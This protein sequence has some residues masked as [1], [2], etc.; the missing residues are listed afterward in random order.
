M[1]VSVQTP[2]WKGQ[3]PGLALPLAA[4]AALPAFVLAALA[5]VA[6]A[7]HLAVNPQH[8]CQVCECGGSGTSQPT[9]LALSQ[10]VSQTVAVIQVLCHA[11]WL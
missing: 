7:V 4:L 6:A 8:M 11:S 9:V 3:L 5:A 1:L 2:S 10:V